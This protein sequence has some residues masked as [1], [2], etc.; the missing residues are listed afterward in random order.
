MAAKSRE[1]TLEVPD[2]DHLPLAEDVIAQ[3][4]QVR[5][6]VIAI[7]VRPSVVDGVT[8][9]PAKH[10]KQRLMDEI[11]PELPGHR[12]REYLSL[13][14]ISAQSVHQ[15]I[16]G[17]VLS[18]VSKLF[19]YQLATKE[20]IE[21]LIPV[22]ADAAREFRSLATDLMTR[23]CEKLAADPQ[24]FADPL[25]WNP[26]FEQ[27]GDLDGSWKHFFHGFECG[28]TQK[29]TGQWVEVRLGFTAGKGIVEFGVLNSRFFERF[30][31]TTPR[32]HALSELFD[33]DTDNVYRALEMLAER[34]YLRF[35][36]GAYH[37]SGWVANEDDML[38]HHGRVNSL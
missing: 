4:R 12:L 22:L 3:A 8:V 35:L 16:E 28:F 26:R 19:I 10:A 1:L 33:Q 5:R 13:D 34:G 38:P 15:N 25:Y 14:P 24:E 30:V 20:Q 31:E 9:D 23:L 7:P 6:I 29:H 36:Q 17:A 37:S 11:G 21:P 32:F 18:G 27:S 2:A